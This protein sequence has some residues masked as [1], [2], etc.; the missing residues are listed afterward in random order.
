MSD[1]CVIKIALSHLISI[2][3]VTLIVPIFIAVVCLLDII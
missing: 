2:N 1:C 3:N